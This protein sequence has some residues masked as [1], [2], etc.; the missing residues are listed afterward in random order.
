[1]DDMVKRADVIHAVHAA[2]FDQCMKDKNTCAGDYS[3]HALAAINALPAVTVT[4]AELHIDT[5]IRCINIH[6]EGHRKSVPELEGALQH[7]EAALPSAP[8]G[9]E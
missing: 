4:D 6:L 3:F 9:K 2:I 7:L 1:M 8:S 5:A